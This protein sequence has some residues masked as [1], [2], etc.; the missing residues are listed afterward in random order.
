M[1]YRTDPEFKNV[2]DL[3]PKTILNSLSANIAILDAQGIIM[4]TN[5][6]WRNYAGENQMK[7]EHDSIGVNYLE[8][9]EAVTGEEATGARKVAEGIRSVINGDRDEFLFDYPCHSSDEKHW[10]YMRVIRIQH[11]HPVH[12]VVSHEDITILKITEESLKKREQELEL[13][14]QNL[15]ESNIAL[16]VLLTQRETDKVDLEKKF[17][18]NIKQMVLP[19]LDKLKKSRLKPREKTFVEIIDAHLNDI[20]SPFLQSLAA[21][22]IFLTPQEMQVAS[23]IKDG[24]G[25]KEIAAL[26]NVSQTTIHF[27]R[28]NLRIKLNITNKPVNLR[29]Y[30]VSLS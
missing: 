3:L 18:I 4:E 22:N 10:H 25:S 13:K 27:H 29:A 11:Q 19:Y 23:L 17:L 5:R 30:L 24:K 21:A 7:G 15:E 12:V 28:K 1:P 2:N 9:C 8:I 20:I 6:A 26:L 14:K 16:K